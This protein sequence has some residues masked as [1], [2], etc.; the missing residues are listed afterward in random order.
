M[1]NS[2]LAGHDEHREFVSYGSIGHPGIMGFPSGYSDTD[3]MYSWRTDTRA[4]DPVGHMV[5]VM[6]EHAERDDHMPIMLHDWLAWM[7][8]P[9][10]EL[11]HVRTF[12]EKGRELGYR[13]ATHVECLGD[14][15]VWRTERKGG[16]KPPLQH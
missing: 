7:H 4:E 2:H 1:I 10:K 13:L 6:E 12:A 8:A 16:V 15:S 11:S 9:D 14:E 5:G 3:W